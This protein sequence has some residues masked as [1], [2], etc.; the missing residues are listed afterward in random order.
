MRRQ[1][2]DS[3]LLRLLHTIAH[4][5]KHVHVDDAPVGA[6]Y[7]EARGLIRRVASFDPFRFELVTGRWPSTGDVPRSECW[8]AT[9]DGLE[10]LERARLEPVT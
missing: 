1:I 3:G 10:Y 4:G 7:L 8:C 9:E 6:P 5:D 2:I